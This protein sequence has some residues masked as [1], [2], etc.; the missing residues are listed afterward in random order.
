MY[1][2]VKCLLLVRWVIRSIIHGEPIE[3]FL[4][5]VN[6]P[7]YGVTYAVVC[8]VL[9]DGAY[10]RVAHVVVA[11]GFLSDYLN[12]LMPYNHKYNVLSA[13]LTKISFL[14]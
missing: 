10:K 2:M 8:A 9:S 13:S 7:Y 14:Q 1:S 11:A 12:G 4:I 6:V 5:P 3:L